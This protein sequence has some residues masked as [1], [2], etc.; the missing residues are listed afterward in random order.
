MLLDSQLSFVPPGGNLSLVAA[1]GVDVPSTNV[2][3]LLGQGVG[4][5]PQNIIGNRTV[6]GAD[7]GIGGIR[8]QVEVIIGTGLVTATVAT[9]NV[10]FQGAADQG[11]AGGYLPSTWRTL[12]ETGEMAVADLIASA[13][14]ARFDFPPSFPVNFQP[15]YLRLLFQVPAA[16]LFTAGTIAAAIVAM[17]RDDLAN[18]YGAGKNYVV[19]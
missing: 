19:A 18:K 14:C 12:V 6:F 10:A 4:T 17:V 7:A 13:I 11:A 8:P 5:E 2:I 15:R 3:D 1:A 9:L 16:T